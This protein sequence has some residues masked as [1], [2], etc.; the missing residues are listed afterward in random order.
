[1]LTVRARSFVRT[2]RESCIGKDLR[3]KSAVNNKKHAL[4]SERST[5]QKRSSKAKR[6]NPL[7]VTTRSGEVSGL[8]TMS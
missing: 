2:H 1:M 3:S 5:E 8:S 6:K 7:A 4:R